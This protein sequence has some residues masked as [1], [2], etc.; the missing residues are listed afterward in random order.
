MVGI[1]VRLDTISIIVTSS[2]SSPRYSSSSSLSPSVSHRLTLAGLRIFALLIVVLDLQYIYVYNN[3]KSNNYSQYLVMIFDNGNHYPPP[4]HPPPHHHHH[5]YP[6]HP[7]H[8]PPY[9]KAIHMFMP[10]AANLLLMLQ[11]SHSQ[12]PIGCIKKPCKYKGINYQLPT[13]T[14][15]Q[16]PNFRTEN[17]VFSTSGLPLKSPNSP[18][19]P[20]CGVAS[21]APSLAPWI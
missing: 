6:Y 2:F 16:P 21:N 1:T 3:T 5:H 17:S 12:P 7:P 15:F 4:H 9:E 8:A 13:S 19:G 11:K 18:D 10:I 20:C 14:G